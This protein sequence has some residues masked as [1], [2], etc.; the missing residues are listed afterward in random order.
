M[1]KES[2]DPKKLIQ[3]LHKREKEWAHFFQSFA[4]GEDGPERLKAQT[5]QWYAELKDR[6]YRGEKQMVE[7]V[8]LELG[9][10]YLDHE[11]PRQTLF[12]ELGIW[13]SKQPQDV[14]D[15]LAASLQTGFEEAWG[16]KLQIF[17][18]YLRSKCQEAV[19]GAEAA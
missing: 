19:S 18:G 17:R 14:Q 10:E 13:A 15:R 9:H 8:L 3:K 11:D 16:S 1:I 7:D 2:K 12:C 4:C 6:G 5:W